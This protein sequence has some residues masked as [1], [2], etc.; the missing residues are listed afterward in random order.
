MFNPLAR[1]KELTKPQVKEYLSTLQELK[2]IPDFPCPQ[3]L[4]LLVGRLKPYRLSLEL[5]CEVATDKLFFYWFSGD[6]ALKAGPN[7]S[8]TAI[9]ETLAELGFKPNPLG[10]APIPDLEKHYFKDNQIDVREEFSFSLPRR[11]IGAETERCGISFLYKM[12]LPKSDSLI[13]LKSTLDSFPIFGCEAL[14]HEWE[15]LLDSEPFWRLGCGGTWE[16][17][18]SWSYYYQFSSQEELNQFCEKLLRQLEAKGFKAEDPASEIQVFRRPETSQPIF[19]LGKRKSKLGLI[20]S[21]QPR[22]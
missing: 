3:A 9:L 8:S 2:H 15:R 13:S 21:V 5:V 7:E 11:F 10:E 22:T 14:D 16:R 1:A 17:Y 19:Y 4:Q 20:L 18:Y 6:T 12:S